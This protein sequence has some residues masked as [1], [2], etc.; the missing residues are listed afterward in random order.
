MIPHRLIR[1][2]PADTTEQVEAW[3]DQACDLHPG[4]E[5]LTFRDPIDPA[6]FP[7][8]SPF[9]GLC[10]TG[11]QMAGLVRLEAVFHFGGWYCDSDVEMLRPLDPL[12]CAEFVAGWEDGITIPDFMFG[13]AR[14]HYVTKILL[15]AACRSVAQGQGAWA[16]G[17]GVFTDCLRGR[18]DVLLLPPQAFAP[19]HYTE[20]DRVDWTGMADRFPYSWAAHHWA[21]SWIP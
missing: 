21:A 2:V 12:C 15:E 20:K 13:A 8:T 6:R 7:L 5:H 3:W 14:G 9:W 11:A 16:S 4:W 1:V 10:G 17:P 19:Y 18:T